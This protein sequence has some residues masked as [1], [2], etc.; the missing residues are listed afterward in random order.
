MD[1]GPGNC[2]I[3]KWIRVNSDNKFDENG[4]IA[5]V[6]KTD[7]FI[8][9]QTI[10]SFY[11]NDISKKKSPGTTSPLSLSKKSGISMNLLESSLGFSSTSKA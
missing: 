1:I 2:L 5:R 6:G 10:D 3:D 11:Y 8:L 4:D 7:K 9:E